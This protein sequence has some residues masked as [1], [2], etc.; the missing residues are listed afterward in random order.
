MA[1]LYRPGI[2]PSRLYYGTDT[3]AQDILVGATVGILLLHRPSSHAPKMHARGSWYAAG[4]W[5]PLRGNG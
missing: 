3:R 2:D 4:G 5:S 1:A